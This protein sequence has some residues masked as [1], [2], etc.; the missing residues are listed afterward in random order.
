MR[1]TTMICVSRPAR[2]TVRSES[3]IAPEGLSVLTSGAARTPA[4]DGNPNEYA[5]KRQPGQAA[6][7]VTRT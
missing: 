5:H 2:W 3:V 7:I 1:S 4:G 6:R